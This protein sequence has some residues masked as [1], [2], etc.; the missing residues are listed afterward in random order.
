MYF[1]NIQNCNF[2]PRSIEHAYFCILNKDLENAEAVF[3]SLDSPRANWGKSL[4]GILRGFLE[5][6]PT[7]FEIRNFFEIDLDFLLKNEKLEYVELLLG[8]LELLSQ[9]NQEAY[10]FAA[11]VMYE[12]KLY[13]ATREYLEKSKKLNYRDPELHFLLS[14]YYMDYHNYSE[15]NYYIEE[16]LKILPDY[17]PAKKQKIAIQKLIS[18]FDTN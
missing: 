1:F 4:V 5:R 8:S 15:A 7:Y 13:N 3:A 11:R 14:K 2:K 18:E 16:C 17:Y 9:I 12:N 10:K 6:F